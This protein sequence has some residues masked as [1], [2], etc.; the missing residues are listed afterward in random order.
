M[1]R[2]AKRPGGGR[3]RWS[4]D[5]PAIAVRSTIS[6]TISDHLFDHGSSRQEDAM[7]MVDHFPAPIC[8]SI[9]PAVQAPSEVGHFRHFNDRRFALRKSVD[10]RTGQGWLARKLVT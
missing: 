8:H 7:V 3:A 2:K 5:T 4:Y 10:C 9:N 1:P 6:T